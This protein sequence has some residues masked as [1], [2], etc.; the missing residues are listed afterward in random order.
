MEIKV[1][2]IPVEG[3]EIELSEEA[4]IFE[5][6]DEDVNAA[7]KVL[8]SF[9]LKKVGATVYLAGSMET[10]ISLV[11][12]RCGKPFEAHVEAGFKL[13]L[14]PFESLPREEEKELHAGDLDV[15]FYKN[16]IIDLREFLRE[17]ILLQVPMKP[18]C[19]EDCRGLCQYCG[20][21]LNI[22]QCACEPPAGHPGLSGLKGLLEE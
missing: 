4:A 20:Q 5:G 15:E 3:L 11:C 8:A 19:T 9:S 18:L 21:D 22:A 6:L 13:D 2:D 12:S 14:V 17:Q 16:G 1:I 7:S 10:E